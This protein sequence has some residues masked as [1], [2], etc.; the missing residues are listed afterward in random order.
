[1]YKD[2]PTQWQDIE[3]QNKTDAEHNYEVFKSNM[4]KIVGSAKDGLDS[5][6]KNYN[7][8]NLI[9]NIDIDKY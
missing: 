6:L 9:F 3:E 4:N 5:W 1:M 7:D 2:N 8:F